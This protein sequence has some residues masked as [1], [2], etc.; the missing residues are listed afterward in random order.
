MMEVLSITLPDWLAE[1]LAGRPDEFP[2]PRQKMELVIQLAARNLAHKSGGPFAAAVFRLDDHRLLAAG[3]NL[4]LASNT[5]LAHA[6]MLALARAQQAAG[7]HDLSRLGS[8][9]LVS[10]AQP[11]VMCYG[12]L[13]WSGIHS[14]LFAA[15]SNDVETL[16]GFREGPLPR[17]WR[18]RLRRA[19]IEVRGGLLRNKAGRVLAAYRDSGGF[20]YNPGN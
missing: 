9:Q 2:D 20:I 3:V 4:V 7:T 13:F 12:A 17:D 18:R 11:C 5:S 15:S 6:E 10:S 1:F 14:L 19:G 8:C 16:T